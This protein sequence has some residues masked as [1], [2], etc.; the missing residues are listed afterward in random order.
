MR[1]SRPGVSVAGRVTDTNGN[2]LEGISV[3]VNPT[4]SGQGGW[5]QTDGKGDYTTTGVVAGTYRVQFSAPGPNPIWAT[6]YWN[7]RVSWN[8]ADLLTVSANDA[9]VRRWYQ[10]RAHGCGQRVGHGDR[11]GWCSGRGDLCQRPGRRAERQRLAR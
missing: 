4:D 11:A 8:N 6:Q 2:P 1:N 5:A 3:N 10:R 9:P 7:A